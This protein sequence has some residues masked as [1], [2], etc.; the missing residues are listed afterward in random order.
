M[1]VKSLAADGR[2]KFSQTARHYPDSDLVFAKG[3]YPYKYM[4]GRDKFLLN[5]LPLINTYSSFSEE[6]ITPEDYERAQKVW[7]EF[8]IE[9]MQQYHDLYLNLDVLL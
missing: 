8:N 2:C 6:T 3:I 5:E 4:D 9:N 1:L 7:R